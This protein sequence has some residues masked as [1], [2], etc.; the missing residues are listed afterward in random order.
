ML[1]LW[2]FT[3][4]FN[5]TSELGQGFPILFRFFEIPYILRNTLRLL[6]LTLENVSSYQ[7]HIGFFNNQTFVLLLNIPQSTELVLCS[8]LVTNFQA[9]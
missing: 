9:D 5:P 7:V 3:T 4:V 1:Y 2:F 8:I 6:S